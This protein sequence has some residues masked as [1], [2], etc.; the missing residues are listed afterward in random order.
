MTSGFL[1]WF[2]LKLLVLTCY[3]YCQQGL[4][5]A[6]NYQRDGEGRLSHKYPI[7]QTRFTEAIEAEDVRT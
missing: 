2:K 7:L 4:L 6:A 5:K 1:P 3:F